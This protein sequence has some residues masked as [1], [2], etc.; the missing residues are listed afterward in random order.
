MSD[1]QSKRQR[2][3]GRCVHWCGRHECA[4]RHAQ[5]REA[6]V[7]KLSRKFGDDNITIRLTCV[8]RNRVRPRH[9]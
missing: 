6:F 9:L 4:M 7:L 1:Y 8:V 2:A 5:E 3:S